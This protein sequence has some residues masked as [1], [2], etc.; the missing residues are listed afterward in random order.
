[1]QNICKEQAAGSGKVALLL[2]AA[3]IALS[4]LTFAAYADESASA[5]AEQA[6]SVNTCEGEM[7]AVSPKDVEYS[8][9]WCGVESN[10]THVVIEKVVHAG[11]HN[12]ATSTVTTCAADAEGAFSYS[13]GDGDPCAVYTPRLRRRRDGNR[14]SACA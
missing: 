10:G 7:R 6:I 13:T 9:S 1:M 2:P 5:T 12:A 4:V 3:V 11:M 14:D 8:P